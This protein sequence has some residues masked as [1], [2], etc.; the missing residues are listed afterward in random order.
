MYDLTNTT[1]SSKPL[2][3][4]LLVSV[5]Y[6]CMSRGEM[7]NINE[8]FSEVFG[9][10]I[11]TFMDDIK[12]YTEIAVSSQMSRIIT[13]I[14]DLL[15]YIDQSRT[16]QQQMVNYIGTVLPDYHITSS[17]YVVGDGDGVMCNINSTVAGCES[18]TCVKFDDSHQLL[19]GEYDHTILH[20][21][22]YVRL[23]I[24]DR[25]KAIHGILNVVTGSEANHPTYSDNLDYYL[26]SYKEDPANSHQVCHLVGKQSHYKK[27]PGKRN[28]PDDLKVKTCCQ[29][30]NKVFTAGSGSNSRFVNIRNIFSDHTKFKD[31]HAL[32]L[33]VYKVLSDW[34]REARLGLTT[35]PD[36]IIFTSR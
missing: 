4:A 21:C 26:I 15:R 6:S 10:R 14:S 18:R 28:V 8:K 33:T 7:R 32:K 5:L 1:V 34:R 35:I 20:A 16:C 2:N 22:Q 19:L 30:I 31:V 3:G 24:I 11:G 13:K 9:Y 12:S 25:L 17:L 27:G 36:R 29:I 23:S